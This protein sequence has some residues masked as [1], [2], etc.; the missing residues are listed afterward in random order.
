[1]DLEFEFEDVNDTYRLRGGFQGTACVNTNQVHPWCVGAP[2][3]S[4][5]GQREDASGEVTVCAT[6]SS[7]MCISIFTKP[8]TVSQ[9]LCLANPQTPA[10]PGSIFLMLFAETTWLVR[11][12]FWPPAIKREPKQGSPH[13]PGEFKS[14]KRLFQCCHFLMWYLSAERWMPEETSL[15]L[16]P[17]GGVLG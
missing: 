8:G 7:S 1:M 5:H 15:A 2:G 9:P 11:S 3:H 17:H 4:W 10:S 13:L 14:F 12:P 16:K 6:A